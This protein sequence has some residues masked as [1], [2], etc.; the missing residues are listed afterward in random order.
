MLLY[1]MLFMVHNIML[2]I[3]TVKMSDNP[4]NINGLNI[5][6]DVSGWKVSRIYVLFTLFLIPL[7]MLLSTPLHQNVWCVESLVS[8]SIAAMIV[9]FGFWRLTIYSLSEN[10]QGYIRLGYS[11]RQLCDRFGEEDVSILVWAY[12]HY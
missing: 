1:G 3:N 9:G 8:S 11:E 7:V 4:I 6:K 10:M 12:K 2:E 5:A